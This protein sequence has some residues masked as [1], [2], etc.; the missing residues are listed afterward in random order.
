VTA[1]PL[2]A[3]R[4]R[5]YSFAYTA[6]HDPAVCDE[7]MVEDYTL[8]MGEFVISGRDRN[9]KPAA[10]KQLQLFPGLGMSVH[11][12][13]VTP[14]R[15]ALQFSEYGRSAITGTTAAWA[16]VSMYHWDGDRLTDCRVEQDYYARRAQLTT[17]RPNV[18]ESPAH[19]P[20]AVPIEEPNPRVEQTARAWVAGNGIAALDIG[21]LDD[22]PVAPPSR[23]VL[24][25]PD[26]QILDCFSGAD[27]AAFHCTAGGIVAQWPGAPA[28]LIGAPAVVYYSGIARFEGGTVTGAR[29]ISDRLAVE[30]RMR[31]Q[32]R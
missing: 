11:D 16:G 17:G 10:I 12:L 9:Y 32:R 13:L 3:E 23:I 24:D 31:A 28:E 30:R 4:L 21:A 1:V 29:V 18:V 25:E 7:L 20:W 2:L 22:E 19:D 14:E 26:Y 15:A 6:A 5:R 8:Y 27:R